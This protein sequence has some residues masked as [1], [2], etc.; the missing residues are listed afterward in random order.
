[1]VRFFVFVIR[2]FNQ[3]DNPSLD[4][5]DYQSGVTFF[6]FYYRESPYFKTNATNQSNCFW[7]FARKR[8]LGKVWKMENLQ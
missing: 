7:Q 8:N 2:Y 1:M 3:S 4:R 6:V 5:G